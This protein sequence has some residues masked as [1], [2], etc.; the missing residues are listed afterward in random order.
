VPQSRFFDQPACW[1]TKLS[2]PTTSVGRRHGVVME[3]DFEA[4]LQQPRRI[5]AV[6]AGYSVHQVDL[7]RS[8]SS[9]N[10]ATLCPDRCDRIV[11]NVP[12]P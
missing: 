2:L 6:T 12:T 11:R 3:P 4:L 1:K 8:G 5:P 9:L 7:T 10:K